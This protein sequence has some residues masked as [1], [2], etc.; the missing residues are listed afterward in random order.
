MEHTPIARGFLQYNCDN[1]IDNR[2][3]K[4]HSDSL[5]TSDFKFSSF[6]HVKALFWGGGVAHQ[7]QL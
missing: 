5:M 6:I 4:S 2:K 7:S 1:S 3:I